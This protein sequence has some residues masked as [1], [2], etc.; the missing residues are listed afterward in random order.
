V[1]S[2]GG[3]ETLSVVFF[4]AFVAASLGITFWAAKVAKG[5]SGFFAAGRTLK[6]WQNGLAIAGDYMS[7]AAFLGIAGIVALSGFDGLMYSIGFVVAWVLVVLVVAEPL[8]NVGKYTITD[9][10]AYR[11]RSRGVR[12]AA[13]ISSVTIVLFYLLAQMVG[14]GAVTT[15][16]LPLD[17][18]VAIALVGALM[19]TYVVV[20]G[21]VA[22]TYVQM[23]KAVLLMA[24]AIVM[25]V[26]LLAQFDF[27]I[28]SLLSSAAE[29]SGKGD[30]FLEPGLLFTNDLDIISLGLGLALGTA[31]LPHI[32][33]RFY[34]VPHAAVARSSVNWVIGINGTFLLM[35]TLLG[36]GAAALVGA[37]AIQAA[38]P[39]GNSAAPML[40]AELGGGSGSV[41]G[42]LLLAFV[43]AVAF[44]TILAVVAGLTIA[45]AA[46]I[47]HD[48]YVH[49]LR[50]GDVD[51]R[52]EVRI[53]KIATVVVGVVAIAISL[54]AK[55][56]NVAFLVGLA[57][58]IAASANLPVLVYALF[59]RRFNSAGAVG[60]IAVGLV[61]AVGLVLVS[62]QV[63]GP[64]GIMLK[65]TEP[66][67]KLTNPGL[68]SIPA[69]FLGGWLVTLLTSREPG[70]EERF[71]E[72]ETRAFSGLGAEQAE[73]VTT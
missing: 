72:F 43:A 22:T 49:F 2:K 25:T 30:A 33:M 21:M 69:G 73:R 44:A 1:I 45:A 28:S 60:A 62:P 10:M 27:N 51:P 47:S 12:A 20:G 15:L 39:G 46:N 57:F 64:E 18:N 52:R 48:V 63:I 40:A 8:R 35:T 66:L 42:D 61:T 23:V 16:L 70:S 38:N 34:T 31:G 58:A 54:A 17:P 53:A 24:S 26:L 55:N 4:A 6:G 41:G 56:L 7:A 36:F 5:A 68:I 14:I 11:L 65:G 67:I 29:A 9:V 19:I 32:M 71:D 59:W 37:S 3:A 50:G 13:A